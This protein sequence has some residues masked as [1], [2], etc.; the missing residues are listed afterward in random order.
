MN[1]SLKKLNLAW[2]GLGYEGA[3]AVG[4]ALRINKHLIEI[5]ISNN[6]INWD[7][8]QLLADMLE[9][10]CYLEI[11]RVNRRSWLVW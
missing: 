8:A 4:E 5:N 2:N 6:R 7:G 1:Y 3:L 11:F 10:N 9:Q